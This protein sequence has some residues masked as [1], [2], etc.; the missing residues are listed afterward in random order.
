MHKPG[1]THLSTPQEAA[2]GGRTTEPGRAREVQRRAVSYW[3]ALAS[4]PRVPLSRPSVSC[5][6]HSRQDKIMILYRP[7]GGQTLTRVT[8]GKRGFCR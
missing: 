8:S 7:L 2:A 6:G 1:A 5:K 3:G 4:D